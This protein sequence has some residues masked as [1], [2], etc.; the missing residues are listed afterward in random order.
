[1]KA[2][3]APGCRRPERPLRQAPARSACGAH[4]Q[5]RRE[6]PSGRT[7]SIDQEAQALEHHGGGLGRD[8][9]DRDGIEP[10]A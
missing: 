1:M 8:V 10:A 4:R 7:S 9:L 5:Q 6:V 3:L 2:P